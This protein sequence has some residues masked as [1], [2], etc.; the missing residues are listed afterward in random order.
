[1]IEIDLQLGKGVLVVDIAASTELL[2]KYLL[3]FAVDN[4][5][6]QFQY[7]EEGLIFDFALFVYVVLDE[8]VITLVDV[9][10]QGFEF[11]FCLIGSRFYVKLGNC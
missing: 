1:M 2:G 7:R 8:V 4:D 5:T 11:C 10:K 3:V 9:L 6:M